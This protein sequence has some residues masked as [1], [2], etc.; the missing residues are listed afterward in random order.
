M[1]SPDFSAA[2]IRELLDQLTLVDDGAHV[3]PLLELVHGIGD[4][5]SVATIAAENYLYCMTP[6][7]ESQKRKY[8]EKMEAA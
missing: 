8:L 1:A 4:P 7:F 6:D 2:R 3:L 5:N